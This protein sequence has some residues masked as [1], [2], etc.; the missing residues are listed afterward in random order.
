[1]IP[2]RISCR[3]AVESDNDGK[4]VGDSVAHLVS[5]DDPPWKHESGIEDWV[6]M[7]PKH[8]A[9]LEPLEITW[10]FLLTRISFRWHDAS[11]GEPERYVVPSG[12]MIRGLLD[13]Y[14][15]NI[16]PWY[17]EREPLAPAEPLR[18]AAEIATKPP[19]PKETAVTLFHCTVGIGRSTAGA[20]LFLAAAEAN[21]VSVAHS[22]ELEGQGT[23]SMKREAQ[24][25]V[26]E[27][28]RVRLM[29]G[30]LMSPNMD[31]IRHGDRL[32]G[33]G[34]EL[35]R[36]TINWVRHRTRSSSYFGV[37]F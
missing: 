20:I 8:A 35:E 19:E 13:H 16:L 15:S 1:M 28:G 6:K 31:M 24:L 29:D 7:F 17:W 26:A 22:M 10:P 25:I 36:A 32:L 23:D 21:L 14:Q 2:I 30:V 11:E 34:G 9:G 4:V 33:W 37:S 18:T 3:D 27:V 5:F 12:A